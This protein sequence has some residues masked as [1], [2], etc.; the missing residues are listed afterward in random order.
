MD[1]VKFLYFRPAGYKKGYRSGEHID[2]VFE[3]CPRLAKYLREHAQCPPYRLCEIL[4]DDN[5]YYF[6]FNLKRD[7]DDPQRILRFIRNVEQI[8]NEG[9]D[10]YLFKYIIM[11]NG[12]LWIPGDLRDL[13]TTKYDVPDSDDARNVYRFFRNLEELLLCIW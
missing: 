11:D 6:H 2:M 8:S 10:E 4:D 7:K 13:I 1:N 3:I 5:L 9:D 12:Q